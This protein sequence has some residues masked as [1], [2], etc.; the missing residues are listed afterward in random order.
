ML[1]FYRTH[2]EPCAFRKLD[3]SIVNTKH[4]DSGKRHKKLTE[5]SAFESKVY[6]GHHTAHVPSYQ[7]AESTAG[8][9]DYQVR[10][11]K[12]K[13]VLC[14]K[15]MLANGADNSAVH[16]FQTLRIFSKL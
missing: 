6:L 16:S 15:T 3:I 7:S 4:V 13:T 12:T 11:T 5:M 8:T 1:E 10:N 14:S 2:T 9:T